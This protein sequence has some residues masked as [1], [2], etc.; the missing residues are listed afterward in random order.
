M[1]ILLKKKRGDR[2]ADGETL[3]VVYANEMEQAIKA[4]AKVVKAYEI[5]AY[6][7]ETLMIKGIVDENCI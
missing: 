3:A 7:G 5:G 4:Y 1:G 2:V 6:A